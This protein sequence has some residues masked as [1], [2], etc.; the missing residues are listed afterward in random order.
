MKKTINYIFN[1]KKDNSVEVLSNIYTAFPC[2]MSTHEIDNDYYEVT[3]TDTIE[4]I[5][6]IEK[7][8]TKYI[9]IKI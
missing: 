6:L 5:N 3:I 4:N 8:I 9:K 1:D 7:R 2:K